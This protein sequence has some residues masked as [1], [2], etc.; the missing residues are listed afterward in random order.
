[1][2]RLACAATL[3][4]LTIALPALELDFLA[5][6]E[7]TFSEGAQRYAGRLDA[8]ITQQ[9]TQDQVLS[10]AVRG[11]LDSDSNTDLALTRFEY[12]GDF[13][14]ADGS[15]VVNITAGRSTIA[16]SSGILA[17]LTLDGVKVGYKM[18]GFVVQGLAATTLLRPE[19]SL[20]LT[21]SDLSEAADESRFF[22]PQRYI[23]GIFLTFPETIGTLNI[24]TE[25]LAQID[26]RGFVATAGDELYTSHYL[27]SG[28]VGPLSP[29]VFGSLFAIGNY[30]TVEAVGTGTTRYIGYG[31]RAE[32]RS[33][34]ATTGLPTG[35]A[36]LFF[37]SGDRDGAL[38]SPPSGQTTTLFAPG[39]YRAPWTLAEI[40]VANVIA[41]TLR[42]SFLPLGWATDPAVRRTRVAARTTTIFRPWEIDPGA[43]GVDPAAGSGFYGTELSAALLVEPFI[44]LDIRATGVIFL[45]V[46]SDIGGV[47]PA[48]SRGSWRISVDAAL[49]F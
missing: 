26:G 16:E 25:Y 47:Y 37:A 17:P 9:F 5:F 10:A 22:G 40:P 27:I 39:P 41:G 42:G 11:S 29:R 4:L 6:G 43:A 38:S 24:F 13:P 18:P 49:A 3:L 46:G 30:G 34:I 31:A 14:T 45:P 20:L 2:R 23:G 48:G 36:S 33:F 44:D 7:A 15:A 21:A 19:E 12:V 1:M 8:V 28:V 32:V 35:A